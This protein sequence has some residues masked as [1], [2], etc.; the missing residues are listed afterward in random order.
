MKINRGV[1][2]GFTAL[3]IILGVP[4]AT[5]YSAVS[6]RWGWSTALADYVAPTTGVSPVV[7]LVSAPWFVALFLFV[8]GIGVGIGIDSLTR[9]VD[10]WRSGKQ[11]W[12][13]LHTFTVK[14]F[15]SL[16]ADV[17]E[18]EFEKSSRAKAI[19][20]EILIYVNSGHMPLALEV[21]N[22]E[23]SFLRLQDQSLAAIFPPYAIKSAGPEATVFKKDLEG[24]ARARKW[25][26]PWPIPS[27]TT[28]GTPLMPPMNALAG[29]IDK[30]SEGSKP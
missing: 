6:D 29:L 12:A 27:K 22:A 21:R 25:E 15:S 10:R 24:L 1:K 5:N 17:P 13:G 9:S 14:S 4:I 3:T 7:A 2:I 23:P 30:A 8:F 16:V 19:A 20:T 11:W 18:S 26:L 28:V